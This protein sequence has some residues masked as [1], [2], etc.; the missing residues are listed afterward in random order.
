MGDPNFQLDPAIAKKATSYLEDL[1]SKL[2]NK[3]MSADDIMLAQS[4]G[5]PSPGK[6]LWDY[7]DSIFTDPEM[8]EYPSDLKDILNGMVTDAEI[9]GHYGNP[10]NIV[11]Q[12]LNALFDQ[13]QDPGYLDAL[14]KS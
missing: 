12:R 14:L 1:F 9:R 10:R 11:T 8:P 5:A 13:T 7:S 2:Y 3:G 6:E 4:Y